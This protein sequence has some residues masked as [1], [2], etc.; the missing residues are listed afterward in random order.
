MLRGKDPA[1]PKY[2]FFEFST[3]DNP[4]LTQSELREEIKDLPERVVQQEIYAQFLEDTGV[5]FRGVSAIANAT[6][7]PPLAGHY[8]TMGVDVAKVEDFT[9]ISI[10]DRNTNAQVF[11]DRFNKL[12]WPYQKEKIKQYSS[13]YN[14]AV[15]YLDATGVGDPIADDLLRDGV[16]VEPVKFS[17]ESKKQLI[18]RLSVYIEQKRIR[19]LNI[20]ESIQELNSF[21]YD[22]S[23]TGKIRYEAPKGF[24]DDIVM[25]TALA[26]WSLQPLTVP[27]KPV[28]KSPIQ[29]HYAQS[30]RGFNEN[31]I[32]EV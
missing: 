12:D 18:E 3:F 23:S 17:N 21:T 32:E 15:V 16:P 4:Y 27:P 2:Q 1:Q 24:H 28:E 6:P 9:V 10:F 19:L 25:A 14:R 31:D 11:Q 7:L 20:P 5:V 29:I 26:V 13:Y 22:V 30:V 8:Y